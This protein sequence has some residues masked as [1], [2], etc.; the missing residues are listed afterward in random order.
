MSG[1]GACLFLLGAA[2]ACYTYAGYPLLLGLATLGRRPL[3]HPA[4][5]R[6][7]VS[8]VVA[9]YDEEAVL[10]RKLENTLAL[11]YPA[12]RL[13]IVVAADGSSDRT[14][15]IAR[16]FASRGVVTSH[17]S[18]RRGKAA[19]IG[20]AVA[21][22]DGEVLVFSDANNAYAPDALE[23]LLAPFAD[24]TVGAVSGAKRILEEG[25]DLGASEGL[26]WRYESWIKERESRL[27]STV[28]VA[29]EILAVRRDAFRPPPVGTINDDL[30]IALDLLARGYRILY[31]PGARSWE[32]VSPTLGEEAERR[33]RIVAGRFQALALLGRRLP[34]RRPGLVW[35]LV[36]HKFLR[37]LVP[38]MLLAM[39]LGNALWLTGGSA[40]AR[41]AAAG[42]LALLALAALG[43]TGVLPGPMGRVA[44]LAAFL[45]RSNLAAVAGLVRFA[46]GRPNALWR[47]ARRRGERPDGDPHA[48]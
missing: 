10:A 18:E 26:Y 8:V 3:R 1:F 23:A 6:P 11:R 21:L 7:R 40:A 38:F 12:E 16:S 20:N 32:R 34:W 2:L 36:S 13:Q 29:G 4:T 22:A 19:A 14:A 9:A 17:R 46:R 15:A 42:Q 24:P 41:T 28:A 37:P 30:W 27:G 33:S 43:P 35:R 39:L 48:P 5:H 44:F 25:D 31:A 47:K 45:L